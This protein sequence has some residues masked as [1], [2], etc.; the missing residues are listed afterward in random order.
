MVKPSDASGGYGI[1]KVTHEDRTALRECFDTLSSVSPSG[2][3]FIEEYVRQVP[4]LKALHPSSLNTARIITILDHDGNAHILGT[5]FRV[6]VGGK[7]VD[8]GASGGI[9]CKLIDDGTIVRCLNKDGAEFINHPDTNRVLVGFTIPEWDAA[10]QLAK[11][12]AMKKPS[13]RFCGWDLALS[14][15]GW[16]MIEGNESSEFI[17]IQIFGDGCKDRITKYL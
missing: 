9:L 12:L 14:E 11:T 16:I 3:I 10:K 5:F 4:E 6:G 1:T 13:I 7:V 15:K 8:N 17:G 2:E